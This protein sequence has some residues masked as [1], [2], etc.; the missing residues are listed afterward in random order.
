[1]GFQSSAPHGARSRRFLPVDLAFLSV[2]AVLVVG[3][4]GCTDNPA[5]IFG[6]NCTIS[7]TLGVGTNAATFPTT[8]QWIRSGPPSV[9]RVYPSGNQAHTE[10]PIVVVFSESMNPGSVSNAFVVVETTTGVEVPSTA[11]LVGDGRVL[12]LFPGVGGF[13]GEEPPTP[14][15]PGSSYEVQLASD[16]N[17]YDLT[18]QRFTDGDG[19]LGS[20]TVAS[21]TS[22]AP[23]V[24]ATWPADG[25]IDASSLTE[26]V[27]VFDRAVDPTSVTAA[28]MLVTVDTVPPQTPPT[29]FTS[30]MIQAPFMEPVPEPRVWS[31]RNEDAD[32]NPV[33]LLTHADVMGGAP[34]VV[35]IAISPPAAPI[36][37]LEMMQEV[38][39]TTVRFTLQRV[40][41]PVQATLMSQPFD[42]IG[43][44]NL[45]DPMG[46]EGDLALDVVLEQGLDGDVLE[47]WL[48]GVVLDS[49]GLPRNAA[50]Q[51]EVVLD[52]DMDTLTLTELELNLAP[53]TDPLTTIVRDGDLG[54]AFRLRRGVRSTQVFV[55]DV[56]PVA[57]GVQDVTLD[58]TPPTLLSLGAQGGPPVEFRSDQRNMTL[59]G[60][61]S[62]IL[63]ECD[64][65]V[66]IGASMFTNG[67]ETP[68]LSSASNGVFLAAPVMLPSNGVVDPSGPTPAFTAILRDRA[69]NTTATP[70]VGDFIQ[71][72]STAPGALVAPGGM[73][74]V[75]VVD[76]RTFAPLE[77]AVVFTHQENMGTITTVSAVVTDVDGRALV[78]AATM[79]DTIVTVDAADHDLFTFHGVTTTRL[80][81]PL[82]PTEEAILTQSGI[83]VISTPD[84]FSALTGFAADSRVDPSLNQLTSM[85]L[86]F[87]GGDGLEG[88]SGSPFIR[89]G[90][91]GNASALGAVFP[92]G[93][94]TYTAQSFLRAFAFAVAR[95]AVNTF[96][97]DAVNLTINRFLDAPS[98][99][100]E[101]LAINWVPE[102]RVV[103]AATTGIDLGMLDGTPRV[104]VQ[105]NV[106]GL[107]GS[108][109][110]GLGV[111]FDD[112]MG[113]YDLRAAY[114]G[115]VDPISSGPM[116]ALGE[117]VAS[118]LIETDLRLR[119]EMSE[120]VVPGTFFAKRAGA[121]PKLSSSPALIFPLGIPTILSPMPLEL[122]GP[123]GFDVVFDGVIFDGIVG[124]GKRGL[125]KV[126]LTGT[127][128]RKWVLYR[129]DQ[130]NVMGQAVRVHAPDISALGGSLLPDSDI[131][132]SVSAYA[133]NGFDLT[134]FLW[135][136]I[137]REYDLF[138]HALPSTFNNQP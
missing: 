67:T 132:V 40:F 130:N 38:A 100:D 97:S 93:I 138:A 68:V 59:F 126:T 44:R 36:S 24:L 105:A 135:T 119:V 136:D 37:D 87:I 56:D 70:L 63:R 127:D 122:T 76:A 48:F 42:A 107:P 85:D 9:E 69:F 26:I 19:L 43:I 120:P 114:P 58:I 20:F 71:V 23:R 115:V 55:M 21:T 81:V 13:L 65:T 78:G 53:T 123:A 11:S 62:E 72:G 27:V 54:L 92:S 7:P 15:Q 10:S 86:C 102:P 18:G 41:T 29:G 47:V 106:P 1:M 118:G 91:V 73:I 109:S 31:Y 80:S 32:G 52:A 129:P 77:N 131:V 3:L 2:L 45:V 112:M 83:G 46:G 16:A 121:R 128:D 34:G 64:V 49:E 6:G 94:G 75:E 110:V 95:P 39:L 66:T 116:D 88:C 99:P 84:T 25:A 104:V 108:L 101:E 57:T 8:G 111:T 61:A 82:Q 35:S 14:L 4:W 17:A 98:T 12:V 50:F 124:L 5:C 133:W 22:A 134:D 96:G 137:E 103:T 117:L 113:G 79:G 30:L 28:S 90:I 51:R 89:R 60:T 33:P 74:E 125:Y